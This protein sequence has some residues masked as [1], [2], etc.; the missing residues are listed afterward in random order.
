M[1]TFVAVL[2]RVL[3]SAIF[4]YQ[5]KS[6]RIKKNM[7]K[8][9]SWLSREDIQAFRVYG[10]DIP[11][12]AAAVDLYQT[13][14]GGYAVVQEYAP[15]KTV[16]ASKA[17]HRLNTMITAVGLSLAV[18]EDSIHVKSRQRR[19]GSHQ[20]G[21]ARAQKGSVRCRRA[22]P[23]SDALLVREGKARLAVN[24]QDYLDTGLFLDHRPIRREIKQ[25]ASGKSFLNRLCYAS[26]VAV[27]AALGEA[28]HS[29]SGEWICPTP[30][31][32][33]RSETS[34]TI[35]WICPDTD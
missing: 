31:W 29:L 16:D 13:D 8:L 24:L 18:D 1:P 4:F 27:Q 21:K 17:R 10:A 33:S 3:Q 26:A 5:R 12:Y 2:L 9:N 7:A 23:D 19:R 14:G 34:D 25:L 28:R 22:G 30:I 35:I 6:V 15:P 20:Y 32:I 11:E